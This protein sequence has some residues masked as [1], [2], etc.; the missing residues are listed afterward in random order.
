MMPRVSGRSDSLYS[1]AKTPSATPTPCVYI[2]S[3]YV[4]VAARGR[5]VLRGLVAALAEVTAPFA[6]RGLFTTY[7]PANLSARRAWEGLGF[8]PLVTVH[9]RRFDPAAVRQH[10]QD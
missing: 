1:Q 4:H 2:D 5:G 6:P 10:Q 3:S 9:Q 8:Q 7:L